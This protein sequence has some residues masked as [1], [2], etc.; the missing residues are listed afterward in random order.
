MIALTEE[1]RLVKKAIEAR[2]GEAFVVT[3][4]PEGVALEPSV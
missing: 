1:P 2:G 3:T 4:D